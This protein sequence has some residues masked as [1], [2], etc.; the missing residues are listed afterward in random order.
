[1]RCLVLAILFFLINGLQASAA[2]IELRPDGYEFTSKDVFTY[3]VEGDLPLGLVD[4]LHLDFSRTAAARTE[5]PTAGKPVWM[6]LPLAS[7]S[8]TVRDWVVWFFDSPNHERVEFYLVESGT[9]HV[10]AQGAS[11]VLVPRAQRTLKKREQG[12]AFSL[13]PGQA[14]DLLIRIESS[15]G[16]R[17]DLRIRSA[18]TFAEA[19][20]LQLA[21]FG[22]YFGFMLFI[23]L[24]STLFS[25][26]AR[27]G[28]F[29]CYAVHSAILGVNS[30]IWLG[31]W[32]LYVTAEPRFSAA[33]LGRV[34][35]V[36]P[37]LFACVF[38]RVFLGTRLRMPFL[39]KLL[40]LGILLGA[41]DVVVS[42]IP[43][44]QE[45]LPWL[46]PLVSAGG[47]LL[48]LA[49]GVTAVVKRVPYAVYYLASITLLIGGGVIYGLGVANVLP[50]NYGS[51]NATFISHI[52][53]AVIMSAAMVQRVRSIYRSA[54]TSE[55]VSLEREKL[56]T[57]LRVVS[58]DLMNPIAAVQGFARLGRLAATPDA[59]ARLFERIVRST[60]SQQEIIESV[61]TMRALEDGKA[62][63]E[64]TRVDLGAVLAEVRSTFEPQFAAK[65]MVLIA[66]EAAFAR[67]AV[68]AD[69]TTL[70]HSVLGNLVSN[71]CKFSPR[72]GTVF[73]RVRHASPRGMS[74][75]H[76]PR[77]VPGVC[78]EIEDH[79]VGMPEVVARHLFDKHA[80]TTR[81]GTDGERGTGYGMPIVKAFVDRFG[82]VIE[83][84]SRPRGDA[85]AQQGTLVRLF[86]LG[87]T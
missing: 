43:G 49:T 7:R 64:L 33:T 81:P 83:V 10:L 13:A 4:A 22:F 23:V 65:D 55:A 52:L 2:P 77:A 45:K 82:G 72:G 78:I 59:A 24:S 56:E 14:A 28:A 60:E 36:A 20:D 11:G 46:V 63:L 51:I 37:T 80:P 50:Q 57:L 86:L 69:K 85:A 12:L 74:G 61:K 54:V 1:M 40:R 34:T 79:G 84:E 32:D 75:R 47:G 16:V 9:E 76:P 62:V 67:V 71:A 53:D 21:F 87:V 44:A 38:A 42:A 31:F 8:P 3:A 29:L 15:H 6:R 27:D 41:L 48:L 68:M 73:L 5:L 35:I 66:D 17:N 25:V 26:G 70:A 58:H 18:A 19:E 39:D 30:F